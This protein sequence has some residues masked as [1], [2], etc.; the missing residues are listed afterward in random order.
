[1]GPLRLLQTGNLYL[2]ASMPFLGLAEEARQAD[3]RATFERLITLAIKAEVDLFVI[4]G[5]LFATA[6]PEPETIDLVLDGF[7]RLSER[8][9]TSVILPGPSDG[10]LRVDSVLRTRQYPGVTLISDE[11]W[12]GMV[13]LDVR[14]K[15]VHIYSAV[16]QYQSA[17]VLRETLTRT[18]LEGYHI[19]LLHGAVGEGEGRRG[20]S[21]FLFS[22]YDLADLQLDYVAFGGED[23]FPI[24]VEERL[25]GASAGCPEGIGFQHT[26]ERHGLLVTLDG[27]S[28]NLE[29]IC[30]NQRALMTFELDVTPFDSLEDIAQEIQRLGGDRRLVRL[31]LA[32]VPRMP[33]WGNTLEARCRDGFFFLEIRD[34]TDIFAAPWFQ[35]LEGEE[36]VLGGVARRAREEDN[37][38][39]GIDRLA[40]DAFRELMGRTLLLAK[41]RR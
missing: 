32:G 38:T 9:I 29:P 27:G 22:P 33:L 21:S 30:V 7:R 34:R 1:M 28:V 13:S 25:I 2:D 11:G 35:E 4:A 16:Y 24:E 17:S 39:P 41:G 10:I 6:E 19:G 37:S 18:E 40:V 8:N 3:L 31:N 26:H 5:N 23:F 20:S 36:T 14:G 15:P 12:G